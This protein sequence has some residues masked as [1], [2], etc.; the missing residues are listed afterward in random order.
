MLFNIVSTMLSVTIVSA[1]LFTIVSTMLFSIDEAT[2]VVN[3]CWTQEKP[4][5]IEQACLLLLSLLLNLFLTS[6]NSIDGT[7]L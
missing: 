3:G 2:T 6:C 1:I 5:L 7:M 4:I